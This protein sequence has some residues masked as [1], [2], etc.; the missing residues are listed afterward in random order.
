MRLTNEECE[1]VQRDVE[2]DFFTI[3]DDK[4]VMLNGEKFY[5]SRDKILAISSRIIA[6]N[7]IV[8]LVITQSTYTTFVSC[9]G[10]W[11]RYSSVTS[12]LSDITSYWINGSSLSNKATVYVVSRT[13]ARKV[14]GVKKSI[15]DKFVK[16][17]GVRCVGDN[18]IITDNG[19]FDYNRTKLSRSPTHAPLEEC[20]Y[21]RR[22]NNG[23]VLVI[24]GIPYIYNFGDEMCTTTINSSVSVTG[25]S[26][27][28][29]SVNGDILMA[30]MPT[31]VVMVSENGSLRGWLVLERMNHSSMYDIVKVHSSSTNTTHDAIQDRNG[32]VWLPF[33]TNNEL[34]LVE[35][36]IKK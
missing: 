19:I 16:L 33:T 13:D 15:D 6:D 23:V 11:Q 17:D 9:G 26:R 1:I 20:S 3:E 8:V 35:C 10:V 4:T 29:M 34:K 31:V 21:A 2:Y 22:I 36:T 28:L 12:S 25:C 32:K 18:V 5:T 30:M 24:S 27:G 7:N 14:K